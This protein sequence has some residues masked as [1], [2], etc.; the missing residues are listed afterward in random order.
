MM[1][2]RSSRVFSLSLSQCLLSSQNEWFG[3]DYQ[4]H[5]DSQIAISLNIMFLY[6]MWLFSL[7]FWSWISSLCKVIASQVFI[8]SPTP[9]NT[10]TKPWSCL[11]SLLPMIVSDYI[12]VM[13]TADQYFMALSVVSVKFSSI[14][15]CGVSQWNCDGF[16]DFSSVMSPGGGKSRRGARYTWYLAPLFDLP[17]LWM[18]YLVIESVE[19]GQKS[20]REYPNSRS[21]SPTLSR[22]LSCDWILSLWWM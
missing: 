15:S 13:T 8:L 6:L 14:V 11:S 4:F 5:N 16:D 20:P 22:P 9:S 19:R 1:L 10:L 2:W 17:W 12:I 18:M 21:S 3:G 7:L